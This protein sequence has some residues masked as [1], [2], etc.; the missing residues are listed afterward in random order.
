MQRKSVVEEIVDVKPFNALQAK[1]VRAGQ[2]E[3]LG[4]DL[5]G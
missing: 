5:H 1:R 4:Q 2:T 3:V